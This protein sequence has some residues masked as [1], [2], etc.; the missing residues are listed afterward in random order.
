M[1]SELLLK[2]TL[3]W[4]E[5]NPRRDHISELWTNYH[6]KMYR[7]YI[8]IQLQVALKIIN[9]SA[10]SQNDVDKINREVKIMKVICYTLCKQYALFQFDV[11]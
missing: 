6:L 1:V 10:L 5:T 9:K 7:L 8:F 3:F 2:I 11:D 4:E